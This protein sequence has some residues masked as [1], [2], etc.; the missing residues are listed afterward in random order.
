MMMDEH[1]NGCGCDDEPYRELTLTAFDGK[2]LDTAQYCASCWADL[3][4]VVAPWATK[5]EES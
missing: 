4:Q 2:T 5:E 3:A 1:C